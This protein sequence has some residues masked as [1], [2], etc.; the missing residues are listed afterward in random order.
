MKTLVIRNIAYR[1]NIKSVIF[2]DFLSFPFVVFVVV[3]DV[4]AAV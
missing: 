1:L 3:V 2:I 4:L